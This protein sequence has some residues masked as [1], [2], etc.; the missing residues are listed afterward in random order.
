[1][2]ETLM[3]AIAAAAIRQI[4]DFPAQALS[5][6]AWAYTTLRCLAADLRE[7]LSLKAQDLL[8]ELELQQIAVLLDANLSCRDLLGRRL[9]GMLWRFMEVIPKTPEQ[10]S[11]EAYWV[12]L[13]K[14]QVDNFGRHGCF[15]VLERL[16]IHKA[17]QSFAKRADQEV[18]RYIR[19]S[20]EALKDLTHQDVMHKRVCSF[21]AY[22]LH[23]PGGARREGAMIRENGFWSA[24]TLRGGKC[25][26]LRAAQNLKVGA[27][28]DR[29]L[30]S[31]FQTLEELCDMIEEA[32]GT[33]LATIRT[34][35]QGS[36]RL[37][38]STIP[39]VSCIGALSQFSQLFPGIKLE[40]CL[41]HLPMRQGWQKDFADKAG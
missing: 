33:D 18:R 6:L 39:C 41:G 26:W 20:N 35:I 5:H 1:M 15:F 3:S 32:G 8:E 19:G 22:E 23:L 10:W 7:A 24:S 21:A 2:D 31:E 27:L 34:Q 30:C 14:L 29:T 11:N 12:Y 38:I 36:L 4:A 16:G 37:F 9:G 13:Q 28:V 40:V 25:R 17:A